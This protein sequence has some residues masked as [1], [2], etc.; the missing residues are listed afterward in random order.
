MTCTLVYMCTCTHVNIYTC[1]LAHTHAR[2]QVFTVTDV[3]TN[4]IDCLRWYG[5]F[6]LSKVRFISWL[7][8]PM[9]EMRFE[10]PLK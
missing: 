5:D 8:S 7:H 6:F 3:H 4:Y 1:T 2:V 9:N 10:V